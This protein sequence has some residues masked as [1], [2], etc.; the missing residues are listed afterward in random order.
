MEKTRQNFTGLSNRYSLNGLSA[1]YALQICTLGGRGKKNKQKLSS[2][3]ITHIY[4]WS[5]TRPNIPIKKKN[6]NKTQ[7]SSSLW[8][9]SYS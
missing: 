8:F 9:Q 5:T 2:T 6:T 7:E 3:H 1:N 4:Y